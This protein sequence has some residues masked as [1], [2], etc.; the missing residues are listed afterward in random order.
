MTALPHRGDPL[1]EVDGRTA[2]SI[3]VTS[4]FGRTAAFA[5]PARELAPMLAGGGLAAFLSDATGADQASGRMYRTKHFAR[6]WLSFREWG[7]SSDD[8]LFLPSATRLSPT[9]QLLA[10][11]GGR[12]LS[13]TGTD[14]PWTN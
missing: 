2:E 11:R 6:H 4:A 3:L 10:M 8:W 14:A 5:A 12:F 1:E 9:G 7:R 13:A